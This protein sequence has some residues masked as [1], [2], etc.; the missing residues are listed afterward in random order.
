MKDTRDLSRVRLTARPWASFHINYPFFL[1][2]HLTSPFSFWVNFI[3][4]DS[5]HMVVPRWEKELETVSFQFHQSR[6]HW[7]A[8]VLLLP[9]AALRSSGFLSLV[10]TSW[11]FSSEDRRGAYSSVQR[12]LLARRRLTLV[13]TASSGVGA[14]FAMSY[15]FFSFLGNAVLEFFFF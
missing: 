15:R 13:K 10:C 8:L 14:P 6:F 1:W 5:S 9:E 12:P 11:L 3:L 4:R 2:N 7:A